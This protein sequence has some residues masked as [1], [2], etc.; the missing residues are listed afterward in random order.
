M[1]LTVEKEIR[2]GVCHVIHR[3]TKANK[4]IWKIMIK[5]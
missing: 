4:N 2:S 5:I 3:Y 1:I